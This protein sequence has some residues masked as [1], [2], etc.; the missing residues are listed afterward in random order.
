MNKFTSLLPIRL[1]FLLIALQTFVS[2]DLNGQCDPPDLIPTDCCTTAPEVCLQDACYS[3]DNLPGCDG[4]HNGW[5][6]S[7]TAIHNPQYFLFTALATTVQINIHVDACTGGG[8][9][10]Q[11]AILGACPWTNSDVLSCNPGTGTGGTMVL[12]ANNMVIGND[13]LLVID[14]CA[15]QV[16][17]YTIDFVSGI[18]E[19]QLDEELTTAFTNEPVVCQGFNNWTATALGPITGAAGYL[20]T[21]FPWGPHTSTYHDMSGPNDPL[22][23][24]T[25]APPGTYEICVI[26]FTGCD[27]TEIPQCFFLTIEALDDEISPPV[28]LCPETYA[29]GVNWNGMPIP[30]AGTYTQT[31]TTPDG[32]VYDS[33]KTYNVFPAGGMGMINHVECN[34]AYFYEGVTYVTGGAYNLFYDNQSFYGCDSTAVLNLVL[35]YIDADATYY[36]QNQQFVLSSNIVFAVPNTT[37]IQYSW[38]NQFGDVVCT[39]PQCVVDNPGIYTLYVSNTI[40]GVTC[41]YAAQTPVVIDLATLAPPPPVF[42]PAPSPNACELDYAVYSINVDQSQQILFWE[43]SNSANAPIF[44]NGGHTVQI[45]WQGTNGGEVCVYAVN[46][47]GAGEPTC[48]EVEVIPSPIAEFVMPMIECVDSATTIVFTGT[49]SFNAQFI[50]NFGS[51]QIISGGTGRGPHVVSWPTTGTKTVSLQVIEV[52]CDTSS[53][54]LTINIESLGAPVIS[55]TSTLTEITFEWPPVPGATGYTVNVLSGPPGVLND[56]AYIVSGLTPGASVQIQV[57]AF[58]SGA[59]G[60][61]SATYECIAQSCP[62]RVLALQIPS[63]SVCIGDQSGPITFTAT[64]DGVVTPGTWSGPG[65]D[66]SGS[67]DAGIAG[68][69]QHQILYVFNE[70]TCVYNRSATVDVFEN[71]TAVFT[72]DQAICQDQA[73]GVL[74]TGTASAAANFMWN[75][76]SAI[77]TGSGAGPYTLRWNA[78]GS[79]NVSLVVEENGCSSPVYSQTVVVDPLLSVPVVNCL[80]TTSSVTISW[81]PVPNATDYQVTHLFGPTGTVNGM[82]Y[83]VTGLTPGDSVAIEIT[84]SGAG[85]CPPVTVVASCVARFCPSPVIT[86]SPVSDICLYPGTGNVNLNVTVTNGNGTGSWSGAGVN[87]VTGV[88]DP[89][90]SGP[91]AKTILYT[92]IDDGC[93][94]VESVT[95]NVYDIPVAVISNTS[96]VLTCDNGNR[97]DLNGSSSTAPGTISYLWT[98][99]NGSIIGPNNQAT[100]TAAAQGTYQLLIRDLVSGCEDMTSVTLTQ[101]D[102]VPI[103]DAGPDGLLDCNISFVVLGGN[104]STGP[105]ISYQ[106]SS[107]DGGVITSD[108]TASRIT[109]TSGGTYVLVV[110]DSANGCVASDQATVSEDY[111]QPTAVL[112]VGSVLTCDTE[113]TTVSATITPG[114]ATYTYLWQTTDGLIQSGAGTSQIVAARPGIYTLYVTSQVNGCR[115]TVS[116]EVIGDDN[117]ITEIETAVTD[118]RCFGDANGQISI[119]S[120]TGGSAPYTYQW[121]VAGTGSSLNN[122]APGSYALTVTDANGCKYFDNFLLPAPGLMN[123]SLGNNLRFNINELVTVTLTVANPAQVADVIWG[124]VAPACPGC[125]VNE[126]PAQTT[127][128]VMVTVIDHNGCEE[129]ATIIL[130]VIRPKN[131]FVPT[132]FSPNGDNINDRF[133][134]SGNTLVLIKA[135][136]VF[137]RWG[138]LVFERLNLPPNSPL[139]GWDGTFNGKV[140]GPGVY[141]YMAELV[142]D[143]NLEEIIKGDITVIR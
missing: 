49:A 118:P 135:L 90:A 56:T 33:I 124:G 65:M 21:G 112:A 111:S 12:V 125:F 88:F 60:Q 52:G 121:N 14:G 10:L 113:T 53:Y 105:D 143:D 46:E 38:V 32:C 68:P 78:A 8:C 43:W 41:T 110:S 91:G 61:Q 116:I 54:T 109:V 29:M 129:T 114:G 66:P 123:P 22:D 30:G 35:I 126:F 28:T 50:W 48:F 23:I 139:D 19:P 16:C 134:I 37:G 57:I 75:F 20:W 85:Q 142:H 103:A 73:A 84:V 117:I 55:C 47:C 104:S 108:P 80:P 27:M 79:Y 5:C 4:S 26:A 18:E 128:P 62:P 122:L 93:T 6:G 136:R 94:F 127:G 140:V 100:A 11:A 130:T 39:D 67:F 58:G 77:A 99:T 2:M 92:Y 98:T 40:N 45:D 70:G 1:F 51:A 89:V 115:D 71:P 101:D 95:F 25:N 64:V 7:N 81:N 102:N 87:A 138:G 69:G 15:G 74:Y 97:L 82:Q 34:S 24:P 106:W 17:Q 107:G 31:I 86:I 141:V 132:V 120:V 13:Y 76:G 133:T 83:E 63:D 36:C 9:G 137:D 59:C 3:T 44:G 42:S 119:L 96:F 72:V 131:I